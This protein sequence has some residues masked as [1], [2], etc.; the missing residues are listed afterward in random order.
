M[1]SFNLP[2]HL[3]VFAERYG[4]FRGTGRNHRRRNRHPGVPRTP[5]PSYPRRHGTKRLVR[6]TPQT[7]RV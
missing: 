3:G 1:P 7:N 6:W 2:R 4:C 5:N